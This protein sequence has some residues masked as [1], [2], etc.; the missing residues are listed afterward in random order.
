[1]DVGAM[2]P[3]MWAFEEREK[4]LE[5]YER[6]SGARMH[7]AYIR[8]GGVAADIPLGFLDDLFIFCNQ[9]IIRIDEMEDM[10]TNNRIWKERLVDVGVVTSLEAVEWGFSGVMLRA[11]GLP[12]DLRKNQPYETYSKI[13]FLVPIGTKGDCYERYIMRIEEMRSSISIIKQALSLLPNG[14]IKIDDYKFVMPSRDLLKN[15]MEAV[16]HHFKLASDGFKVLAGE[17]YTATEAPKGEF[18]VY[19]ISNGTERPYR[20]KIKAPGF[21]HLQALN[22]MVKGH[23]ISDVVTIIGTQDIV[24]GEIDR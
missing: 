13:N 23:M 1:M 24:F 16:I 18:G 5:F 7:A 10:L 2:T 4:L 11:S 22:D 6:V 9:F 8:P 12:W 14:L 21:A 3:F 19:L 15:S 20:C 17:T